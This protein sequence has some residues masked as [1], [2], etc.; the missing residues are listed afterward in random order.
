M[1]ACLACCDSSRS[2]RRFSSTNGSVNENGCKGLRLT[3]AAARTRILWTKFLKYGVNSD[4]A[5]N[6]AII[7]EGVCIFTTS[8]ISGT[9]S[10]ALRASALYSGPSKT[11]KG[12]S[13]CR[14]AKTCPATIPK[15]SRLVSRIQCSI[16]PCAS[17]RPWRDEL[18]AN[19][20]T[21]CPLR[22][23]ICAA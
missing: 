14:A 19:T 10:I 18:E 8:G 4:G 1:A 3:I 17:N 22:H 5:F 13:A 9:N 16:T 20:S 7:S 21:S 2:T 12:R 23:I 6:M 11:S 15:S